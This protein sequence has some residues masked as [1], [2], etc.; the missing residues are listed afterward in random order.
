M[1]RSPRPVLGRTATFWSSAV[2]LAL[3]LWASGAPSVLYP[4]YAADWHLTPVITTSVFGTYPVALLAVLLLFGG[5]SDAIGRRRAILI[6]VALIGIA[7]AVFATASGA[8]S[9]FIGR[10]L[11]GVGTGFA[12]SAASAS[13]VESSPFRSPRLASSLTTAST[14]GGLTL[15]L[16]V[17][18]VLAQF[19][20]LPLVL[21]YLVLALLSA[22]ALVL[23]ALTPDDSATG[24]RFAPRP[25]RPAPGIR[26][27]IAIAAVS[28][29]I[30]YAVGAMFLSLGAQMARELTG[31]N[32][33]AVIGALLGISTIVILVTSLLISRV[34]ALASVTTGALASLAAVLLMALA[35]AS[36]SL[37]LFVAW[38]VV[39]G[40]GYG[41][42]FTGGLAL[43]S[44]A[45][46]A[47]HRGATLSLVY[48][49]S[50]LVQA[51]TAVGAG[52][53]ATAVG[54]GEAVDLVAP[55]LAVL[56]ALG[57]ALVGVSAAASRRRAATA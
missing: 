4:V 13:L 10:A 11:Q 48:L 33:L 56:C 5:I 55:L 7:S 36:G 3:S 37:V 39:G 46:P 50:Y 47:H 26:L 30:A 35:A 21:S 20:P 40:V 24:V 8:P 14:S 16:V 52:A 44:R 29:S 51:V 6:G 12:L 38:C 54:L 25:L 22:V 15:S 19:L 2:V 45:A 34:P 28:V 17:S 9:L 53:I 27:P 42:A 49:V 31:T 57:L 23:V 43:V 32:D 18:G 1:P 41:F